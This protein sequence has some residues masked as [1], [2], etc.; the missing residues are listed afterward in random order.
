MV[1]EG[2]GKAQED[3]SITRYSTVALVQ[4]PAS[5]TIRRSPLRLVSARRFNTA[6]II[7][8]TF[9][10]GHRVNHWLCEQID[11]NSASETHFDHPVCQHTYRAVPRSYRALTK[12]I[13]AI[14]VA[15]TGVR[16]LVL[17][18]AII[19]FNVF[20]TKAERRIPCIPKRV[21]GRRLRRH[22]H[23]CRLKVNRPSVIPIIFA[24]SIASSRATVAM[25]FPPLAG[26]FWRAF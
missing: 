8:L 7:I 9:N 17:L 26:S 2:R 10:R 6:S 1:K 24:Q 23:P 21:V 3:R 22:S 13:C 11:S 14:H 4:L 20:I 16:V 25:F 12:Y 5:P 19:A 18:L 15:D